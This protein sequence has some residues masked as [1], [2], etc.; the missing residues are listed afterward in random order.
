MV[1]DV[2]GTVVAIRAGADSVDV[3]IGEDTPAT[4]DFL[5]MLPM[6]VSLEEFNGKEKI[7]DLPRELEYE[8]APGSDPE[9]GDL[10]YFVPWGNIGFYYDTEGIEY[11][12]D[13]FHLG[14]YD[15]NEAEL[16]QFEG[17]ETRVEIVE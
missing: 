5:R 8:G 11:S 17:Q 14:T 12:D 3:T 1:E 10:I 15:A 7:A 4:R 9:D 2:E 6:T 13:T 16:A